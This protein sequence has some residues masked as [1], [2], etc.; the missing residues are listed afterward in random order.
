VILDGERV[1]G[2][3]WHDGPGTAHAEVVALRQ[4]GPRARGATVICTLEPCSHHGRTP[5]CADALVAAGVARV[6]VGCPDPLERDRAGGMAVLTQAGINVVIAPDD[7]AAACREQNAPF[8][9]HASRGRPHVT[10]KLATSLDGKVA[11]ETGE[12]RWITGDAARDRVHEWRAEA[13]AVAVGIGTAL[14]DD[15]ALTA[16]DRAFDHTPP[17]RVVFDRLGRL[18]L[19]SALV[20][21]AADSP[22]VVVTGPGADRHNVDALVAHGVGVLAAGDLSDALRQLAGRDVQSLFLEGGP[23]LA[24]SFLAAGLV[25]QVAWFVAPT[26]IGGDRA[27]NALAGPG[28]GALAEVPRLLGVTVEQVGEDVLIQ[29]RLTDLSVV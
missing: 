19:G 26:L 3:G 10:L 27:P 15:P 21:S 11:T 14:V 16:R 2:E 9:T 25:D 8:V 5:P 13:D 17:T 1:V 28:L 18:P 7:E 6:V 12:T 4:A 20:R 23:T 24:R 22:V 29:G